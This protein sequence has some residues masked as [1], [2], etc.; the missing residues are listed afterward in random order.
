[1][2]NI[3]GRKELELKGLK[4]K[5]DYMENIKKLLFLSNL[6]GVGPVAINKN[7]VPTLNKY[8]KFEDLLSSIYSK[9]DSDSIEKA[10]NQTDIILNQVNDNDVSIITLFD[11]DYPEK[12]NQLKNNK[13]PLL[14]VKG[15]ADLLSKA[16]LSVIGTRKPSKSCEEFEYEFVQKVI[17]LSNRVIISGLALGCDK[18]AHTATVDMGKETIAILPSGINKITPSKH[19]KL[20]N[21]ILDNEG[22]LLSSFKPNEGA[23]RGSYLKRDTLIAALSGA[24]FAV[25]CSEKS[26]TMHTVKDAYKFKCKLAA[27][28]PSENNGDFSGNELI[29]NRYCGFKVDS[30]DKINDFM[31]FI[32][33][34][35][36]KDIQVTF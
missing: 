21:D 9:F 31:D 34:S 4:N 11:K 1:M 33:K 36:L 30:I 28:L 18:I 8:E 35:N 12:F 7:Y 13:P 24:V 6:K 27:Y 17:K 32:N 2:K 22:C 15:N 3:T 25:Q 16:N 10:I 19:K 20:A 29:I 5:G 23:N 14:Y 26:G